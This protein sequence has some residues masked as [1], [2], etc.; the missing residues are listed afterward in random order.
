[1]IITPITIMIEELTE[2]YIDDGDGG[3]AGYNHRH[4]V[5]FYYGQ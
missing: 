3:V 4:E 1:M 2:N 5:T